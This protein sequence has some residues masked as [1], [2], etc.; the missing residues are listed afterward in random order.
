[1]SF[2]RELLDITSVTPDTFV[3]SVVSTTFLPEI[4]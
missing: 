4:L 2:S 3:T 1:M